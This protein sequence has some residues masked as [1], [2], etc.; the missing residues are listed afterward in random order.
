SIEE[1]PLIYTYW[2]NKAYYAAA[3]LKRKGLV[4]S[5]VSRAHGFDVYEDR[6]PNH[7]MPLKRQFVK[8]IDNLSAISKKGRSYLCATYGIAE[9]ITS[10]D[11]LGVELSHKVS[12]PGGPMVLTILSVSYCVEVK[13]IHKIIEA[14]DICSGTK[15]EMNFIWH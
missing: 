3:L 10:V 15:P 8:D 13:S 14:I 7:Y 12:P 2:F 1:K 9:N 11:P 5:L 4:G 6:K